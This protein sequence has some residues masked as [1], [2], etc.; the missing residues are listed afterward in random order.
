MCLGRVSPP[1][2]PIKEQIYRRL[3]IP[4]AQ[5][6]MNLSWSADK[7]PEKTTCLFYGVGGVEPGAGQPASAEVNDNDGC[8]QIAAAWT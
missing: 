5:L 1:V 3:N 6:T 7:S 8:R 2:L 4:R